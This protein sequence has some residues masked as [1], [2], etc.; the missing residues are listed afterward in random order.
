MLENDIGLVGTSSTNPTIPTNRGTTSYAGLTLSSKTTQLAGSRTASSSDYMQ[1][2]RTNFVSYGVFLVS[3]WD[4]LPQV[5]T[6]GLGE[7]PYIMREQ[8]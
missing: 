2:S 5:T 6:R 7:K 4:H 3:Y 1:Q 8:S